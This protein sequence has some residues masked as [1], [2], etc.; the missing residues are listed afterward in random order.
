[1]WAC[2]SCKARLHFRVSSPA[3]ASVV[4]EE[5]GGRFFLLLLPSRWYDGD[6]S[7]EEDPIESDCSTHT[8]DA[9]NMEPCHVTITSST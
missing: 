6:D 8:I 2:V 5:G 7:S 1:M 4:R 3:A 9:S